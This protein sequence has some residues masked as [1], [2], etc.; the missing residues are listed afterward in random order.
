[1]KEKQVE[2]GRETKREAERGHWRERGRDHGRGAW[3]G[4]VCV[5]RHPGYCF[6]E[7]GDW[8]CLFIQPLPHAEPH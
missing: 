3:V 1:M 7:R 8:L 2:I 6:N 4:L 5:G